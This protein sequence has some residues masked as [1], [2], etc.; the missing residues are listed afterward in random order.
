MPPEPDLQVLELRDLTK[1]RP[2]DRIQFVTA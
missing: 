2:D 1:E